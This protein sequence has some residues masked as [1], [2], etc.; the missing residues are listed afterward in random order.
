MI[1]T[2]NGGKVTEGQHYTTQELGAKFPQVMK[3]KVEING[4]DLLFVTIKNKKMYQNE[5]QHDGLVHQTKD[6]T[7]LAEYGVKNTRPSKPT[8]IF[9]RYFQEGP[10]LY[11]GELDYIARYDIK[12]N[13]LFIKD[14]R[15]PKSRATD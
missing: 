1:K 15:Q 11:L 13:K 5:L 3:G 7:P 14:N 4:E 8:H 2:I 6:A 10:Y 12:R 9:V